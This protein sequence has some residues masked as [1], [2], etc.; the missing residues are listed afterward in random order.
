MCC[1]AVQDTYTRLPWEEEA[2]LQEVEARLHQ[3]EEEAPDKE[4]PHQE[5]PKS[6]QFTGRIS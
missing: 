6:A 3:V 2:H 1:K 4:A 5:P